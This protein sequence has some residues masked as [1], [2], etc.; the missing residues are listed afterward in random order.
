MND[1]SDC[2]GKMGK[3]PS[4]LWTPYL[5]QFNRGTMESINSQK[6][7]VSTMCVWRPMRY[8]SANGYATPSRHQFKEKFIVI[9]KL[10]LSHL[11]VFRCLGTLTRTVLD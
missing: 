8:T 10:I 3:T 9:S 5:L 6:L 1:S 7:F 4:S 2:C 11:S